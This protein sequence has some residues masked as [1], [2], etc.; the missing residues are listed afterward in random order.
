MRTF[1]YVNEI[2]GGTSQ[3]RRPPSVLQNEA[4]ERWVAA[5]FVLSVVISIGRLFG[6]ADGGLVAFALRSA[7]TAD[8]RV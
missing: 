2:Q 8:T 7:S 6:Q 5:Y 1:T 3:K 4:A